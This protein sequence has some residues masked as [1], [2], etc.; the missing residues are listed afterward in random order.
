MI[1]AEP[2]AP[3]TQAGSAA[4][5]WLRALA[6]TAPIASRPE[7]VL[8]AVVCE[9][10][11]SR[12]DAPALLSD[13]ECFTYTQL[14]GRMHQYARW[15]LDHDIGKG[16][17]VCLLMP[18]R[19]EYFAIWLGITSAGGVVA[20]LNT[21]LSGAALAHG[22]RA[23][24][25]RHIIVGA[26]MAATLLS[27]LSSQ[28]M[29]AV[30]VHGSDCAPFPRIDHEADKY[31]T[32]ALS[33]A[34]RRSVTVH[35][36]ALCI[37]TSGTTGL[38]KAAKVSHARVMQWSHW[39]AGMMDAQPED[40]MYNCLPMY[41]SVG[42]VQAPGALL[43]AGGSVVIRERF[44]AGRFWSDIARWD[45]TMFQ[46]IGELCRYLLNTPLTP[47]D[48][49]HRIRMA[50]GNGLAGEVWA[51]LQERFSIPQILEFYASTEG[52]VSL[53]NAEGKPGAVGRVP[54]YLTH[55]FSPALI[56]ID[57]VTEEPV[58][59]AEGLCVRCAAQQ[60]GEAIGRVSED[61]AHLGSRFEGYLDAAA[62]D[63]KLLRKVFTPGDAWVR[64]GDLMRRDEKGFF[65]FVDRVGDTFRW[66]GENV[67][68]CEVADAICQFPGITGAA[69]YGVAVAQGDGRAGMATVSHA[70]EL[71]LPAL[72]RYLA[73][74]LPS[75]A[76]PVFLRLR[77]TTQL[78]MTGTFKYVKRDL[79][80]QG[81]APVAGSDA[82]YFNSSEAD[83][84]VPLDEE[85]YAR[86][87]SG[88]LR[89]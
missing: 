80:R 9:H 77:Q 18:N 70:E 71:D 14:A 8:A 64:T 75:Y 2:S 79:I 78:E 51:R 73:D 4:K 50:C 81:Y 85:M 68:T 62:S 43:A 15:A 76:R 11:A 66:K 89:I 22:I 74:R 46:Y 7:R 83:A 41:H 32:N 60:V 40:R 13:Q 55:R 1:V 47:H 45:C 35:D 24:S 69:V 58:R 19:P 57:P 28:E 65:Y 17:V 36:P 3:G 29:P 84:F 54:G 44:S 6:L 27:A 52:G 86:I 23:V 12:G 42:G 16:D 82:L 63:R 49:A 25:P 59:N 5:A 39:F 33:D 37:Y 26:S 87:Q 88:R 31:A 38:P 21:N 34:E 20:L 53:F 48:K 30:S 61:P 72:R 67:A 10:A 56:V